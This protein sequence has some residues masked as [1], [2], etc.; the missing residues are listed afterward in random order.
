MYKDKP[1]V[2]GME[3]VNEP[4]QYTPIEELKRFYWEGYLIVKSIAPDWKFIMHD[5]FRFNV[6]TWGGFMQGCPDIA[7]DTHIYQAW[8]NPGDI[9]SFYSDACGKKDIILEMERSFGPV[10]VGEWSLA[11]DNCAMWLN[12]FND[13]LPGFPKLTCK[14]VPCPDPY[15]GDEQPGAPPDPTKPIQ[16]PYGT[17]ISSPSF[18]LCP[19]DIDWFEL[20]SGKV[21]QN[22][23][24]ARQFG[25][26]EIITEENSEVATDAVMK[27][28]AHKKLQ[29]FDVGHGWYFWNFKTELEAQW[30]YLEATNRGWFPDNL[31]FLSSE[32]DSACYKEDH[33]MYLCVAKRGIFESTIKAGMMYAAGSDNAWIAPL[34]GEE[35][36]KHADELFTGYWQQHRIEGATCDFGGAAELKELKTNSTMPGAEEDG[37]TDVEGSVAADAG[38]GGMGL[39]FAA[40]VVVGL[41]GYG[42]RSKL[43]SGGGGLSRADALADNGSG[44]AN[45][46][47]SGNG[48]AAR[49]G[50]AT[51]SGYERVADAGLDFPAASYHGDVEMRAV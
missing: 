26:Q 29:A 16:Q 2:L 34:H 1:A 35:L 50:K 18:G 23:I 51:R 44:G 6:D 37:D 9:T 41:L 39:L 13:N 12:G 32:T 40:V 31:D 22:G 4:W 45:G 5:A 10:V 36:L 49:Q 33:G 21:V 30:S 14:F 8:M 27:S 15:M 7:I 48:G 11:T 47:G 46:S 42:V 25:E 17:G 43:R 28:L 38:A 19:V 20:Q 3:P 24:V